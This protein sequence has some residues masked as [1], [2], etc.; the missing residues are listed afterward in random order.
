M[1][2]THFLDSVNRVDLFFGTTCVE[3]PCLGLR[4]I[5]VR[6]VG[7]HGEAGSS[8]LRATFL[9]LLDCDL[10]TCTSA[11][12]LPK[13]FPGLPTAC[14]P[15][16]TPPCPPHLP[17]S[18]LQPALSCR[19]FYASTVNVELLPAALLHHPVPELHACASAVCSKGTRLAQLMW[20]LPCYPH[21]QSVWHN[22][23]F[24]DL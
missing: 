13:T 11:R 17:Q 10:T 14:R 1:L 16:P 23:C 12:L 5:P 24:S 19:G 22:G 20:H 7:N 21:S 9:L 15:S 8:G 2:R 6:R 4:I 18:W 3:K